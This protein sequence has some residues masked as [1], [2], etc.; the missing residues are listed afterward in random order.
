MIGSKFGYAGQNQ[1]YSPDS[2]LASINRRIEDLANKLIPARVIDVILD[3][4]YPDFETYGGWNSIGDIKYELVNSIEN[5][6]VTKKIAKPLLANIKNFPL[7]NEIV[8]LIKL[9]DTNSLNSL[10]TKEIY[11]YLNAIALWNHPHH[12]AFPNPLNNSTIS[13][14]QKKDYKSIG[15]GNFRRVGDKDVT[16]KSTEINLNSTNNNGGKFVERINIHPILPFTGD[17]I[18]EGRFGNSIRLGST[19]KSKSQYK[20]N[21]STSGNEGDPIIIIRNGQPTNSSDEGWLPSVEN[22][23]S[24][25]SSIYFTSTQKLPINVSSINYTGI[26]NEYIPIFPQ[27]YNLPQVILNSGRLLLNSTTD[28][29]LLSSKKVISLSAIEDI[30]LS[31]RGNIS[32][33]SKGV[34]LGGSEANESLIMGDSFIFQFNKLL[35]SLSLLCE[36]LTTEPALKSTPLIA[37]GIRNT[38]EAIKKTSNT[39]TS[40]ISKTL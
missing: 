21:W 17:N 36:A 20:N 26:R 40:K 8:F 1:A 25:L 22:I 2:S 34:R 28:S 13:E 15:D 16:D 6:Q 11:Y 35:D 7:K 10:T 30:G 19:V 9:P 33:S 4:T 3:E 38:I 23:N 31:S 24:D 37:T 29:I 18:F 14:S 32:L 27:S 39:F 12:N 5:E